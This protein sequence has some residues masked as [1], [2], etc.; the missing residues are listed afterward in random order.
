MLRNSTLDRTGLP[1]L[2]L[3][4]SLLL[5]GCPTGG[6]STPIN[7]DSVS[8]SQTV[9]QPGETITIVASATGQDGEDLSYAWTADAGELS[10]ASASETTWTAPDV[11]QL[12]R[13][14]LVVSGDEDRDASVGF[15]LVVGTGIDHDGDGYTIREGDCDDTNSAIYPGAP[16]VQ[17][18][19]DNDCDGQLDEGAPESDD[20]GDGYADLD[21][22][23]DDGD[24]DVNPD[25]VEQ[26]NGIDDN[27]DG[28]ADEGTEAYDDDGDGFSEQ[29]GDCNDL[30][31]AVA[32]GAPE[33]LDGVDNNCDG[34]IDEG[35]AAHDDDGDGLSEL[36]GDCDDEDA[37]AFPTATEV[38]DGA[39]NDCNGV[40][41]DGPFAID[42]DND[43]WS[44]LA[45][46]CDDDNAY[47]F[48][49]APEWADGEDNDCDGSIDE[50]MDTVDDDGDGQTE[51][52]GDCDDYVDTVYTGAPEIADT[53]DFDNDCDGWY[54][55]NPPFA[56]ATTGATSVACGTLVLLDGSG[57]WDPDNDALDYY[58]YF[59]FQPINS[60]AINGDIIGGTSP[61][62]SF[63]PDVPGV[64]QVSLIVND[65]L[66]NSA[67]ANITLDVTSGS[68]C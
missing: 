44:E 42:D 27:C 61:N 8:L 37:T 63:L 56:A 35:T 47:T 12:V 21:G 51:A 48:P 46:D 24:P 20:D 55:V 40:I 59:S 64:W 14:E 5:A 66:F 13:L 18:G 1:P 67:A 34:T 9:V 23:C 33:L 29:D 41:D 32:P 10:A 65:G 68:G 58:W 43:G 16:D 45:G 57:S 6:V 39:D 3:L 31:S 28:R 2:A 50:D 15:D 22:D 11:A 53:P 19:F 36:D 26:I 52:D 60:D 25:A 7:I 4:F 17:D 49:G 54:F 30:S 38:P 62:A